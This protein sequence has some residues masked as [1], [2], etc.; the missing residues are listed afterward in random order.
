MHVLVVAFI[1]SSCA[2]VSGEQLA[3][4]IDG[5]SERLAAALARRHGLRYVGRVGQLKG[6][7]LF[8]ELPTN[9]ATT[10]ENNGNIS[11]QRLARRSLQLDRAVARLSTDRRVRWLERQKP[12]RRVKRDEPSDSSIADA[13]VAK[14]ADA[15]N[16][17]ADTAAGGDRDDVASNEGDDESDCIETQRIVPN[18]P[19]ISK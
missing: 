3:V 19:I 7:F 8:E 13:T 5:N 15:L 1:A 10:T 12:H 16:D 6:Y 2:F 9:G 14:S 4:H 11:T 17:D 18:W